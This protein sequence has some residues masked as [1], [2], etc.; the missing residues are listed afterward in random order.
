[1]VSGNKLVTANSGDSRAVVG[2]LKDRTYK[3]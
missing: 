2:S 3:L 1:M